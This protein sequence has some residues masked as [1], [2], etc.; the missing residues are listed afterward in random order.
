MQKPEMAKSGGEEI[1]P[2]ATSQ[3][4]LD[5][6][7]RPFDRLAAAR[8]LEKAKEERM[9]SA[10]QAIASGEVE[11]LR[12]RLSEQFSEWGLDD[13]AV[14]LALDLV[15]ERA[16]R[17]VELGKRVMRTPNGTFDPPPASDFLAAS[18]PKL[19]SI[20]RDFRAKLE[21]IVGSLERAYLVNEIAYQVETAHFAATAPERAAKAA[22]STKKLQY[23][24]DQMKKDL[25]PDYAQKLREKFGDSGAE[26]ILDIDRRR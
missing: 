19:T 16:V 5:A 7:I 22:A 2:H 3:T 24:I 26:A 11:R 6:S 25:G 17:R 18:S 14:E 1:T 4:Q 21:P 23:H 10:A 8:T 12:A 9:R 13:F 20:E 15:H